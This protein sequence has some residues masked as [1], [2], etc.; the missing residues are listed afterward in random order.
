[1]KKTIVVEIDEESNDVQIHG[2]NLSGQ[3]IEILKQGIMNAGLHVYICATR[4]AVE[5]EIF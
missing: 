4:R 5:H 1:M 2:R 3:D